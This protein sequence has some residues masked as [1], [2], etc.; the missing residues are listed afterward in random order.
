MDTLFGTSWKTSLFGYLA[1][2]VLVVQGMVE[3][4]TVW[5]HDWPGRLKVIGGVVIAAWGRVQK[6]HNVSNAPNPADAQAVP[7]TVKP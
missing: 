4:G 3:A 6:D 5:P 1:G 2:V 7:P